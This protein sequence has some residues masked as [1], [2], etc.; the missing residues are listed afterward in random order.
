MIHPILTKEQEDIQMPLLREFCELINE[1]EEPG[2]VLEFGTGGGGSGDT[3][4]KIIKKERKLFTFDGFRGL[5]ETKKVIPNGTGWVIGAYSFDETE[6]RK[7]L[8]HHSNVVIT[9][10]MTWELKDPNEYGIDKI[11]GSNMDLYLYEGTLDA[12]RFMDK[13][14]WNTL[15]LRFDDWGCYVFQIASEVDQHEKAA[16]FDWIKETNHQ[17]E[18]HEERLKWAEGRQ[19]LITIKR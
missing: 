12:L 16:F 6:T 19:S 17:Y 11:I 5:P 3:I 4:A 9:K 7:S 10:A 8:E 15:H 18:I 14:T 13:C 2:D 1:S